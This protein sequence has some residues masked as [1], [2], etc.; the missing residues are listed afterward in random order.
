MTKQELAATFNKT[1]EYLTD[2]YWNMYTQI[3]Q[4]FP[5]VPAEE[6]DRV[7]SDAVN[8]V[9]TALTNSSSAVCTAVKETVNKE[10]NDG[11]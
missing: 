4:A 10:F 8:Q 9:T 2:V 6:R 11:R 7:V 3:E 5:N 1:A